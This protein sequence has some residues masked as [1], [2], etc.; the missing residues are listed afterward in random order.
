MLMCFE[1]VSRPA[2]RNCKLGTC[3]QSAKCLEYLRKAKWYR[4]GQVNGRRESR[5]LESD[6]EPPAPVQGAQLPAKNGR[7]PGLFRADQQTERL[8]AWAMLAEGK[9]AHSLFSPVR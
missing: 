1:L 3:Q 9:S 7:I 4:M 2:K 5:T 8:S 6:S